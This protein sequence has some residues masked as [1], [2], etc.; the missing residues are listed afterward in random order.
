MEILK[1]LHI[2]FRSKVRIGGREVDF[3]IGTYAIELDGHLQDASKNKMLISLGYNPIHFDSW[4]VPNPYLEEW[5]NI[6]GRI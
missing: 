1:K 2:P 3:L 4:E 5:L 6:Y